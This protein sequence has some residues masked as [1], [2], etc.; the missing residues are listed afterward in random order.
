MGVYV[1]WKVEGATARETWVPL[2]IVLLGTFHY[3]QL[4]TVKWAIVLT[5]LVTVLAG[6]FVW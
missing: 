6:G 2:P 1:R 4:Q 3:L 5:E